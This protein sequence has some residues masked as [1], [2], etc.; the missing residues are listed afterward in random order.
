MPFLPFVYGY[1]SSSP[2]AHC[3]SNKSVPTQRGHLLCRHGPIYT[4]P[5]PKALT[6]CSPLDFRRSSIAGGL[7]MQRNINSQCLWVCPWGRCR[8]CRR[9]RWWQLQC[10]C[11]SGT[12]LWSGLTAHTARTQDHPGRGQQ[13]KTKQKTT[14]PFTTV[15]FT[16][17]YV[18]T[19]AFSQWGNA[20][21]VTD[22]CLTSTLWTKSTHGHAWAVRNLS[23]KLHRLWD[24][25]RATER[26][27][28]LSLIHIWR[29]RRG[30]ECRSRWSPYH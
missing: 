21:T 29:C 17:F 3:T 6:E 2:R 10:G 20:N 15:M 4:G 1:P 13:N 11:P 25:A 24:F 22:I 8:V 14:T 9:W 26:E 27:R 19:S 18:L 7:C 5:C 23:V 16:W 28:E 12:G 30:A